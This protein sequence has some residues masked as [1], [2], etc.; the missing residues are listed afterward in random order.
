MN[1][2]AFR[3]LRLLAQ[4][5]SCEG[6]NVSWF[7][8]PNRSLA[9]AAVFGWV[10]CNE[11]EPVDVATTSVVGSSLD[12]AP[13]S[14]V[15]GP[16]SASSS[17][18]RSAP[19]SVPSA[20]AAPSTSASA[21]VALSSSKP[22]YLKENPDC[23]VPRGFEAGWSWKR[24]HRVK[25]L[26][27]RALILTLDV[28][29][30]IEN[31]EKVLDVLRDHEVKSTIF[32]YSGELES[33][34]YS[35]AVL[36][37]MVEE[38]HELANHTLSHKDLTKLAPEA[39]DEQFDRVEALLQKHVKTSAKP[40]FREPFLATN[41][42]IDTLIRKKCYRP[43]W[44][45][46]DTAD[47]KTGATAEGIEKS[48]FERRGKPRVIEPGSIFIF[49]GSQKA[50]LVALPRIIERLKG[51]GWSFLTLGEALRRSGGV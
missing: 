20:T 41:D 50:N 24:L 30:R 46:I 22:V 10:A 2:T 23:P 33:H 44:F 48:V 19:S 42:E 7:S 26:T 4:R 5:G 14:S 40:F 11:R 6:G 28:G 49:H 37:R 16:L 38:G 15:R 17:T 3:I 39:L 13:E 31:L 32:V 43:I 9:C 1:S 8:P 27:E 51:D 45:T 21:S 25:G 18:E 47:W 12:P 36:K 35:E 29:A 34:P